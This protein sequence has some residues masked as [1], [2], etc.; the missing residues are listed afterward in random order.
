MH[1]TVL[2]PQG[3]A[4]FPLVVINH[5]STES[6]ELRAEYSQPTFEVAAPWF[7]KR[8]YV[9]V[10]PQRP[11]HGETEGPYLET[12]GSC[13]QADYEQSGYATAESIRTVI[14]YMQAQ[15][16]VRKGP[17]LLAGHSAGAWGALALA[18]RTPGLAKAVINFS[19]GRGGRSFGIANRNCA[20]DRLVS[21]AYAYGRMVRVP[22]LW[23]YAANDTFIGPDL[24]RRMA[25]AFRAG[26]A[27]TDYRLLPAVPGEG[28]SLVYSADGARLWEPVV[29]KFLNGLR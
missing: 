13:D 8:G 25:E 20:P 1:T 28:H 2:L 24:S 23:L 6:A 4:P 27:P 22:T 5:G 15:P 10:L 29:E 14:D 9:V 7:Q 18:S 11:G 3:K 17:V 19:G 26:G 12:A 16:F 21:A